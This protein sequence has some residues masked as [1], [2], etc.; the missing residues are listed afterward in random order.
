[1]SIKECSRRE[2]SCEE[3]LDNAEIQ[4]T[5]GRKRQREEDD[6]LETHGKVQKIASS[7]HSPI[8]PEKAPINL[9]VE[10]YLGAVSQR[11]PELSEERY[12]NGAPS[13][14][15]LRLSS[16]VPN[17]LFLKNASERYLNLFGRD[18]DQIC[19]TSDLGK[20]NQYHKRAV[21]YHRQSLDAD[22]M[23][24]RLQ[25]QIR[26]QL[27]FDTMVTQDATEQHQHSRL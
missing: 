13:N 15:P 18:I 23:S 1:M 26:N 4:Y 21:N 2:L 17:A 16:L 10:R 12:L 22:R 11:P 7:P 27:Q 19:A 25:T 8:S 5:N 9:R 20:K 24:M 6:A 3:S 14:P